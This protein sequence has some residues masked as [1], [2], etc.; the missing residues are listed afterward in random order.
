MA[1]IKI[2]IASIESN[3]TPKETFLAMML[4]PSACEKP[5]PLSTADTQ[6]DEVPIQSTP[7]PSDTIIIDC[8]P[9][10]EYGESSSEGE[11]LERLWQP[12]AA[13]KP[14]VAKLVVENEK[15]KDVLSS[16][17]FFFVMK[18]FTRV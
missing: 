9:L 6:E 5:A 15:M 11:S 3:P 17:S 13:C 4:P 12:C 18:Y 16:I 1:E 10:T 8:S 14:E 7:S 2:Y